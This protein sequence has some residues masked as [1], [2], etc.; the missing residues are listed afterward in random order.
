MVLDFYASD[1]STLKQR[2]KIP[3]TDLGK[4]LTKKKNKYPIKKSFINVPYM[5]SSDMQAKPILVSLY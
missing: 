2:S 3:G 1:V 5:I 4:P